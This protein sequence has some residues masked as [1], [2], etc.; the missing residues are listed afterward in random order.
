MY[1]ALILAA[2][3]LAC[4]CGYGFGFGRGGAL[5]LIPLAVLAVIVTQSMRGEAMV[6]LL[7]YGGAMLIAA[8]LLGLGIGRFLRRS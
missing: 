4:A 6:L 5:M 3:I 8:T 2:F 7:A 1:L